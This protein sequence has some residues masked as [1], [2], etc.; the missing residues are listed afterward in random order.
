MK[1]NRKQN[2]YMICVKNNKNNNY[3]NRNYSRKKVSKWIEE[4]I[5]VLFFVANGRSRHTNVHPLNFHW[6]EFN[7][8]GYDFSFINK[9]LLG[10]C[11][12]CRYYSV[13]LSDQLEQFS[14]QWS[15]IPRTECNTQHSKE[16][17]THILLVIPF[18]FGHFVLCAYVFWVQNKSFFDKRTKKL[19]FVSFAWIMI[20]FQ[21]RSLKF[22]NDIKISDFMW[23]LSLL[24]IV[25]KM[26]ENDLMH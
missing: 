20:Y 26:F 8:N 9:L 1:R 6:M 17:T 15:S 18:L 5:S 4:V 7:S 19:V 10:L 22:E 11:C 24:C 25:K 2:V 3:W 12:C 13:A 21:N 23:S 16:M 14:N